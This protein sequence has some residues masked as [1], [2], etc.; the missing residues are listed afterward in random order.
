MDAR[1]GSIAGNG[2]YDSSTSA[3]IGCSPRCEALI[4]RLLL[5]VPFEPSVLLIQ[6]AVDFADQLMELGGILLVRRLFAEFHPTFFGFAFH[7]GSSHRNSGRDGTS[8]GAGVTLRVSRLDGIHQGFRQ[9][10]LLQNFVYTEPGSQ[11]H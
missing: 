2:S 9:I 7:G 3:R 1:A 5:W 11:F 10:H 8:R 6:Q 4:F